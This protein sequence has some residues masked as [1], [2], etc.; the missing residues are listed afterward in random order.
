M[1]TQEHHLVKIQKHADI[2]V[3]QVKDEYVRK[4]QESEELF[5][6]SWAKHTKEAIYS[7]CRFFSIIY[8]YFN[9]QLFLYSYGV[10]IND[11]IL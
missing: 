2:R 10:K 7:L 4:L 11:I 3:Q 5:Q 8:E 9:Q 6:Q 1:K